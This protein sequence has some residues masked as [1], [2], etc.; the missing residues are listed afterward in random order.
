MCA[1]AAIINRSFSHYLKIG[2]YRASKATLH[3]IVNLPSF[4][5]ARRCRYHIENAV[6]AGQ[7]STVRQLPALIAKPLGFSIFLGFLGTVV[8]QK[9]TYISTKQWQNAARCKKVKPW[10]V[11]ASRATSGICELEEQCYAGNSVVSARTL[12]QY[13]IIPR[14]P[15]PRGLSTSPHQSIL[16]CSC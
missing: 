3:F 12:R 8:I 13:P 11:S 6:V 5:Q 9:K 7:F 2:K 4:S 15:R 14:A 10:H 16:Y 1:V